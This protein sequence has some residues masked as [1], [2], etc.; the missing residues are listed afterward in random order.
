MQDGRSCICTPIDGIDTHRTGCADYRL[1]I[2][3]ITYR[4]IADNHTG[5]GRVL[6]CDKPRSLIDIVRC[7]F[8]SKYIGCYH[9]FTH[10]FWHDFDEFNHRLTSLTESCKDERASVIKV[11]HEV[12][13]GILDISDVKIFV[14]ASPEMRIF[15]RIARNTALMGQTVEFIGDYYLKCARY[16][17]AEFSLASAHHSD[18]HV[19][20]EWGFDIEAEA[21]RIEE[22]LNKK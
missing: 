11:G 13:E 18:M 10:L 14:D 21:E 12:I 6:C 16:R 1:D 19:D 17:E 22:M 2:L 15:R 4:V 3:H 8:I 7:Y 5:I 20:N 9:T